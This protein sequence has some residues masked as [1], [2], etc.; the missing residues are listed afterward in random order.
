[1]LNVKL[2]I[3]LFSL[4]QSDARF[5][6][7][8]SNIRFAFDQS[9]ARFLLFGSVN[10]SLIRCTRGRLLKITLILSVAVKSMS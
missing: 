8:Q 1:M 10:A 3:D 6:L 9:D 7:D 4:D 2:T 5:A